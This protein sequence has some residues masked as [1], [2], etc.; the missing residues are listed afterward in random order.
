MGHIR[1][2]FGK[3]CEKK[4][5]NLADSQWG[6]QDSKADSASLRRRH[7]SQKRV[8]SLFNNYIGNISEW[9]QVPQIRK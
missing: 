9:S 1:P 2:F 7:G 5:S 8:V 3:L 6:G 4:V